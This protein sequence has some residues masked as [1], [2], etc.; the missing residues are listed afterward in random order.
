MY[1][2]A[3]RD[4]VV[5]MTT[6]PAAACTGSAALIAVTGLLG[7]FAPAVAGMLALVGTGERRRG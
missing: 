5:T 3:R 4:I 6:T 2:A 7:G 1:R